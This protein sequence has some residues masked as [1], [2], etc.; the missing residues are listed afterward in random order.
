MNANRV[1]QIMGTTYSFELPVICTKNI[2]YAI[3]R[4]IRWLVYANVY[5]EYVEGY[6]ESVEGYV[7][8][9]EGYVSGYLQWINILV[10]H[11]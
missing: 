5:F 4:Y 7:E 9:V 8:Y 10:E 6:V 1:M 11:T 2:K 3:K